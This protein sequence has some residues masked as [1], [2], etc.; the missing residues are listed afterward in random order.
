M[1]E[2]AAQRS[3][4]RLG[5]GDS[6]DIMPYSRLVVDTAGDQR[7]SMMAISGRGK[8]CAAKQAQSSRA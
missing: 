8:E 7:V 4:T 3:I 5:G 1:T 2:S 6:P